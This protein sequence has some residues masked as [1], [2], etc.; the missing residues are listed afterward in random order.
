MDC[1][2]KVIHENTTVA[3]IVGHPIRPGDNV[4]LLGVD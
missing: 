4:I 3:T 1:S 2:V